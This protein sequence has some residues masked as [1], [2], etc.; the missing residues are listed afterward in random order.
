MEQNVKLKILVTIEIDK[1]IFP[2]SADENIKEDIEDIV[3][4]FFHEQDGIEIKTL[5]IE[6]K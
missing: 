2:M 1:E 3:E 6:G 5:R 4:D